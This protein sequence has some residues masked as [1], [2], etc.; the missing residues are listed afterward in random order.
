MFVL[1]VLPLGPYSFLEEVVVGFLCEFG[2]GGNVV[3]SFVC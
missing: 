3:L 2:N 1:L